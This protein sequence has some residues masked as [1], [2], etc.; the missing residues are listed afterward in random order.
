MKQ[1]I[2]S[3]VLMLLTLII[4]LSGCTTTK[5]TIYLQDVQ[6]NGQISTPPVHLSDKDS[7]GSFTISPRFAINSGTKKLSGKINEHSKVNDEGILQLDTIMH[8]GQPAYRISSANTYEY[9]K[10][11]FT[12]NLPEFSAGVDIDMKVSKGLALSLGLGFTNQNN[13]SLV[14]GNFGLAVY[15]SNE[16]SS[17]RIEGGLLYNQ[18]H[19]IASTVVVTTV[20][21]AFAPEYSY[22]TFYKDREKESHLNPYL[23][24]TYNSS[25]KNLPANF[26][27]SF[28]FFGQTLTDFEPDNFD[29]D[30]TFYG[31]HTISEDTRGEISTT[32]LNF[33]P[34][35]YF[36][37]T[38]QHRILFGARCLYQFGFEKVSKNFF[39]LPFAQ[40]DF[41]L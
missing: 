5:Q 38:P 19:Y 36:N 3:S 13:I 22:V 29:T 11:N 31:S 26:F 24:I 27:I 33:S 30:Y 40:L 34:G 25:N 28:G 2:L 39:V 17:F 18:I 16:N 7:A 20:T 12:W 23:Q 37:I 8:D 35:I 4:F 41:T 32:F 1:T 9:A 21:P 14:N 6:V 15:S 10:D